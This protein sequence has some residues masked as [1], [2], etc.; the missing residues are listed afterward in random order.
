MRTASS[1]KDE[2]PEIRSARNFFV[3]V[4]LPVSTNQV[5]EFNF[6]RLLQTRMTETSVRYGHDAERTNI[7]IIEKLVMEHANRSP[8]RVGT[9]ILDT[10]DER[11]IGIVVDSSP[12]VR[13]QNQL[14]RC[15]EKI[16]KYISAQ[17]Q[18]RR[19]EYMT[20]DMRVWYKERR[21]VC[22][23]PRPEQKVWWL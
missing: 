20:S 17:R 22:E 10:S 3:A 19:G 14:R 8:M 16:I 11:N 18:G 4:Q 9:H 2:H 5:Q 21:K 7:P 23:V 12:L 6:D 13:N 1:R 15:F